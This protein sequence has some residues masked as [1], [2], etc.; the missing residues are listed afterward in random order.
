MEVKF[1]GDMRMTPAWYVRP[2]AHLPPWWVLRPNSPVQWSTDQWATFQPGNLGSK[3]CTSILNPAVLAPRTLLLPLSHISSSCSHADKSY[4]PRSSHKTWAGGRTLFAKYPDFWK[5][6][7]MNLLD[8]HFSRRIPICVMLCS[9]T[10]NQTRGSWLGWGNLP[11]IFPGKHE[12]SWST[13]SA[14]PG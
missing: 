3:V 9:W 7:W 8:L 11:T 2:S 1:V 10:D 6:H 5:N 13:S 14:Q 4:K 12:P